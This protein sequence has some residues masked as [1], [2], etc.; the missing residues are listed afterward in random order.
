MQ[1]AVT[2]DCVC[3]ELSFTRP[4]S[5]SASVRVRHMGVTLCP[6]SPLHS[7]DIAM[8]DAAYPESTADMAAASKADRNSMT[9]DP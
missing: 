3:E 6:K 1:E 8:L 7:P 4:V 5:L 2:V 9:G